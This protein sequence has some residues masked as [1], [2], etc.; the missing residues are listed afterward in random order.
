M[1]LVMS[2]ALEIH[3]RALPSHGLTF[4]AGRF[5]FHLGDPV[6]VDV[7]ARKRSGGRE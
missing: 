2:P 1:I 5:L 4:E 7:E 6:R 3:L